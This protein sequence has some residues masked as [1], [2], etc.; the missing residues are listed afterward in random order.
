MKYLIEMT[1]VSS[2]AFSLYKVEFEKP[3]LEAKQHIWQSMLPSLSA[4]DAEILATKY[5]FSGGQIENIAR[6]HSV[7]EILTGHSVELNRLIEFCNEERLDQP[8][9]R[10]RIGF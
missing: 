2:Y 3:S 7:E 10:R 5:D 6:K 8:G 9:H 1:P 4:T